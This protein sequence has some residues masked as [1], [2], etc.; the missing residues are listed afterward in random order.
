MKGNTLKRLAIALILLFLLILCSCSS[1]GALLRSNISG[2]PYWYYSPEMGIGRSKTALV[3]EGKASTQRQATLLAYAD[4]VQT[5]SDMLGYDLGQEV[6]RELS[7]LGTIT[8]FGLEIQDEF[9]MT[10]DGEVSVYLHA[11]MDEALI[12]QATTAERK[13]RAETARTVESLVLSGDDFIKS[14]Q[15]LRAI[16]NYLQAMAISYG[17]DYIDAEYSFDS[18]YDVVVDLLDS[19]TLSLVSGRPANATCTISLQRKG[20]FLSAAVTSAE[21][22]A[23]FDAVDTKGVIYEDSFVFVTDQNGL[24]TFNT[25]ND[26]LVRTGTVVFSLNLGDEL[27]VLLQSTDAAKAQVL[28]DLADAKKVSFDYSRVYSRGDIAVSVIEHDTLGYVTGVTDTTDY[29]VEKFTSDGAKAN[30]YYAQLDDEEDVLYDFQHS[31]RTEACIAIIRVGQTTRV[32]SN[33]GNVYVGVEGLAT[34]FDCRT[35]AVLYKSD[36]IY[37]GAFA[38]SYDEAVQQAFRKLADIAYSL[39]KVAYV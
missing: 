10:Q 14:G 15:E 33:T 25:I 35:S 5:L 31:D 11:V 22:L 17:L 3:G 12:D 1:I 37:G 21:I 20:T 28:K 19:I 9:S 2:L 29:L 8:E 30:S 6:Y 24:F 27:D 13:R 16:R 23:T 38:P 39:L 34:L 26:A 18:L 7:V 4:V 36:V 32:D